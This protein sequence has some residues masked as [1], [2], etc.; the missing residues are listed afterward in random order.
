MLV[1]MLAVSVGL[2]FSCTGLVVGVK[3]LRRRR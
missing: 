1:L 3:R 2:L